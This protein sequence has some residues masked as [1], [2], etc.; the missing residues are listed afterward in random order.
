MCQNAHTPYQGY[1]DAAYLPALRGKVLFEKFGGFSERFEKPK[2]FLL[3]LKEQEIF[4]FMLDLGLFV[5]IN[6]GP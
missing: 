4:W 6:S 5:C 2:P 1:R 3:K